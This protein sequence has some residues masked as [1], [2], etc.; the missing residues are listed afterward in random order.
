[1]R[2]EN[3]LR[4]LL[5][6]SSPIHSRRLVALLGCV[7]ALV[8]GGSLT[9]TS[10]GRWLR[11]GTTQKHAIK[12]VDRLVANPRLRRELPWFC[13]RIARAVVGA[14]PRPVICIDWT[15]VGVNRW[16]LVAAAPVA[17]RAIPLLFE[18]R[19]EVRLGNRRVQ[20]RFLERLAAILPAGCHPIIVA[21]AGFSRPF[22]AKLV[23]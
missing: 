5:G 22:Y 10:L 17:G 13:S 15:S 16:A 3:I 21:D 19:P 8:A 11:T 2:V 23:E 6:S 20:H 9:L 1:V 4:R 18:V 12:R 14:T 7:H